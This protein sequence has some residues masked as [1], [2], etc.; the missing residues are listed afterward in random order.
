MASRLEKS[1]C[2]GHHPTNQGQETPDAI[3]HHPSAEKIVALSHFSGCQLAPGFGQLN[4]GIVG[5]SHREDSVRHNAHSQNSSRGIKPSQIVRR[6]AAG[7]DG[8][9][10]VEE[11]GRRGSR[12]RRIL[13]LAGII[14]FIPQ[15]DDCT[16]RH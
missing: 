2:D 11:C 5:W 7:V 13:G 14:D 16:W 6:G 3:Q 9:G 15:L 12:N 1:R 10:E 8:P 4:K